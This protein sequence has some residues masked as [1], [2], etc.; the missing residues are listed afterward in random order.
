MDERERQRGL[1]LHND[2]KPQFDLS[3]NGPLTNSTSTLN[4]AN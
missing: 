1:G 3:A 2:K 4:N